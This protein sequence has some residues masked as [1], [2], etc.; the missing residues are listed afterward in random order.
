[1]WP[2]KSYLGSRLTYGVAGNGVVVPEKTPD[3]NITP[4]LAFPRLRDHGLLL[5]PISNSTTR[6]HDKK[7]AEATCKSK[8][9][10][11]NARTKFL[12]PVPEV[13][14][15]SLAN[16]AA[17]FDD[18]QVVDP[19]RGSA[20]AIFEIGTGGYSYLLV[21]D[22][23]REFPKAKN[24][25]VQMQA[26]AYASGEF[27]T[28]L[29]V[30]V[31]MPKKKRLFGFD[32]S[33]D[34]LSYEKKVTAAFP[35]KTVQLTFPTEIL[36]IVAF[37]HS[38]LLAVRTGVEVTILSHSWRNDPGEKG[39]EFNKVSSIPSKQLSGNMFAHVEV[40]PYVNGEFLTMDDDGNAA[41]WKCDA[42]NQVEPI[43]KVCQVAVPSGPKEFSRWRKVIW[44][45]DPQAVLSFARSDISMVRFSG[46]KQKVVSANMWSHIQDVAVAGPFAF[47]LTSKEIIW[48]EKTDNTP[49]SRIISWKHFLDDTD[50]SYKM[51]L[52]VCEQERCFICAV[53]SSRSSLIMMYTFGFV[54][55]N[56]CMT[57]DPYYIPAD[58][59][60][61]TD[62]AMSKCAFSGDGDDTLVNVLQVGKMGDVC[63]S[64]LSGARKKAFKV[65]FPSK[66]P[67][68]GAA[69][70]Q[71]FSKIQTYEAVTAYVHYSNEDLLPNETPNQD[72]DS[73]SEIE[74]QDEQIQQF[75]FRLGA[76]VDELFEGDNETPQASTNAP[77]NTFIDTKVKVPVPL[78][79]VAG[80]VPLSVVDHDQLDNMLDQLGRH[81][82]SVGLSL[83][84]HIQA[85]PA[86]NRG[87][88]E[89]LGVTEITEE[90]N[91]VTVKALRKKLAKTY[92]HSP[93]V[94][95]AATL[96]A[97]RMLQVADKNF[98]SD[99]QAAWNEELASA[100]LEV[101]SV[102][103]DWD[104][105]E[106][107]EEQPTAQVSQ[108]LQPMVPTINT[109]PKS[110]TK[111]TLR[112]TKNGLLHRAITQSQTVVS[113]P[114]SGGAPSQSFT[115]NLT[116]ASQMS[117]QAVNL[118]AS[119]PSQPGASQI[120]LSPPSSQP[121][122]PIRR[123]GSQISSQKRK[124]RKGGFA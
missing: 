40:N 111:K 93:H 7:P 115:Q 3:S 73:Q 16:E 32:D 2:A 108:F 101:R 105:A 114:I 41:V 58:C 109:Q 50:A 48:T 123:M 116:H 121:S 117:S 110:Q 11:H 80:T 42:A 18:D 35:A 86:K 8:K 52:L 37:P 96:L 78:A 88:A 97:T 89:P 6:I 46:E 14:V 59:E 83:Q 47:L 20:A 82:L 60:Q 70:V 26:M 34:D 23:K 75:A 107:Q 15:T 112:N 100:S 22:G 45:H 44:S 98:S 79:L 31:L 33:P 30:S 119:Q 56:P 1:M 103:D 28:V 106:I 74:G 27:R 61:L 12:A 104:E 87:Q 21:V 91:M 19:M 64:V 77:K 29:N 4:K 66:K 62:V 54:D 13:M 36:Q 94:G 63:F 49:M 84:N 38:K 67:W 76:N 113:Q 120:S 55:G 5:S 57:R 10:P 118:D 72:V 102:L 71:L 90:G 69:H 25:F 122:Q 9:R 39:L 68:D 17:I 85:M 65:K 92:K 43:S 124:K 51:C 53:Y 24:N 95:H 99:L 81:Y